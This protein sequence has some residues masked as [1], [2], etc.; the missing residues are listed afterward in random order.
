MSVTAEVI[1]RG[2]F[3]FNLS[4]DLSVIR[5]SVDHQSAFSNKREFEFNVARKNSLGSWINE[6]SAIRA[7]MGDLFEDGFTGSGEDLIL[8]ITRSWPAQK[9]YLFTKQRQANDEKIRTTFSVLSG[10]MQRLC[11]STP[12]VLK[13]S[14]FGR[15]KKGD[16]DGLYRRDLSYLNRNAYLLDKDEEIKFNTLQTFFTAIDNSA[17]DP[18]ALEVLREYCKN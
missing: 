5:G 10:L 6:D 9:E 14:F 4:P 12:E 15:N 7:E 16:L 2:D 18:V 11:R 8:E 1:L 3:R 17:V 13:E